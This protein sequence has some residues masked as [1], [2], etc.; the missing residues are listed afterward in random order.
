MRTRM[1][2]RNL[3]PEIFAFKPADG[4]PHGRVYIA[5]E[6]WMVLKLGNRG[7]AGTYFPIFSTG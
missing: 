6:D 3:P 2:N 4:C 1:R 7:Q 5:D